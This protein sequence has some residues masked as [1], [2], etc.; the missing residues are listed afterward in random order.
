M[1]SR[2]HHW[3]FFSVDLLKR[4]DSR[5]FDE[6]HSPQIWIRVHDLH[7]DHLT[8]ENF[9]LLKRDL[10]NFTATY[11]VT[12]HLRF[13]LVDRKDC[14]KMFSRDVSR[15]SSWFSKTISSTKLI[16]LKSSTVL[17]EMCPS[18]S[19]SYLEDRETVLETRRE[20][21]VYVSSRTSLVLSKCPWTLRLWIVMIVM[22]MSEF[23]T[24]KIGISH[25]RPYLFSWFFV[26]GSWLSIWCGMS[27]HT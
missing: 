5:Y 23:E 27:L 4:H 6:T 22:N 8:W 1:T 14:E 15:N 10:L 25:F 18:T 17:P 7:H 19:L 24:R 2:S 13:Q 9:S 11:T 26:D 12:D 21:I 3:F 16:S 20:M